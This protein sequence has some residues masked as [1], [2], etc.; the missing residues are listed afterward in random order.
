MA[1]AAGQGQHLRGHVLGQA[2]VEVRRVGVQHL[3]HAG[4]LRRRGGRSGGAGTGHQHVDLAAT[5]QRGGHGVERGA[6]DGRVVVFGNDEGCHGQITFAS[7]LSLA[8]S[9]ATSGTFTP[10]PRLGG[11][12]TLS[13]LMRGATSTPRSAGLSVS[14]GFFLAFMMLGS[15]T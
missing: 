5:G 4:D 10:A 14:S 6:L 3:G 7:F 12:D 2:V 13:V 1:V 8:T 15:V 11:S 9:A